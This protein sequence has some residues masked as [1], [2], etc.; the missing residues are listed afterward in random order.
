MTLRMLTAGESHGPAL[1]AI[2]EG[3]PAGLEVS[4]EK[5]DAELR[6]R[7]QGSGAGERM[8]IEQDRGRI[9]AGVMEGMTTGAPIGML[10]ENRDHGYWHDR[11]IQAFTTPRPGHADLVGAIK[12]GYQDLRPALERASARETAARVA[13][14]AV[15]K[16]LLGQFGIK[17][18]S[19]VVSIGEISAEM[20]L[21]TY[22]DRFTQAEQNPAR[23][24]DPE[25]AEAMVA[26]IQQ[27]KEAGDTLGGVIEAAGL[28]IPPGLGA[29][30]EWDR[31]L[32]ARLGAAMLSIP[33]IKGVEVGNAFENS[34]RT[35][36]QAQD[37]IGLKGEALTRGSNRCGGLEGG[38]TN[39]EPL[40]LRLAMKPIASTRTPQQT[41]DLAQGKETPTAYVR[42][43]VCPVARAAP[44][45][46]AMMAFIM[47]D[48]LIEKLGGDSI[49]EMRP[50]FEA[51][52][53]ARLPDLKMETR[54]HVYWPEKKA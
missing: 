1:M 51:L 6:R 31:R 40:I 18:G 37:A 35:G 39:G 8:A 27:A 23:C 19:Y 42:S 15:C 41:V 49:G 52:R 47:A 38:I 45:A 32:E 43:D 11:A 46:E 7:Q 44:V 13:I 33:A 17:I 20:G 36:T 12:Y 54:D 30:D 24:P 25:A 10:I 34:K 21:T 50:R 14:G 4:E 9:L 48:A 16:L 3:I 28:N 29:Y 2:L 26:R 5:I 22:E 53:R